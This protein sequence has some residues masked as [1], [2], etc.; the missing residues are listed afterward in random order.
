MLSL[1]SSQAQTPTIT[2]LAATGVTD[3]NAVFNGTIDQNGVTFSRKA[4]DYGPPLV[5]V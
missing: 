3:S 2:T 5:S 4:T 1:L